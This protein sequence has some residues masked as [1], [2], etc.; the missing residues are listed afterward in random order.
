M[1]IT[2]IDLKKIREDLDYNIG[3]L[4]S[5]QSKLNNKKFVHNAPP[6]VV[7]NERQKEK[8]TITKIEILEKKLKK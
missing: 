3:F 4:K 6:D 7:K 2:I 8:D 5:I 1:N